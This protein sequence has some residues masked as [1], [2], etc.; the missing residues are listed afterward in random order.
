[1]IFLL[2]SALLKSKTGIEAGTS[3]S[4]TLA[5]EEEE[6]MRLL[7]ELRRVLE[8]SPVMCHRDGTLI[9]R[10]K[11][12]SCIECSER[13]PK[14]SILGRILEVQRLGE[15]V[16]RIYQLYEKICPV[17][18]KAAG[19]SPAL[20]SHGFSSSSTVGDC[21]WNSSGEE[22]GCEFGSSSSSEFSEDDDEATLSA[23]DIE[24]PG[25]KC[26]ESEKWL[27]EIPNI[28]RVLEKKELLLLQQ[29]LVAATAKDCSIMITFS[30]LRA[31]PNRVNE[32]SSSAG[33]EE[34]DLILRDLNGNEH[35]VRLGVAD[36]DPKP[37]SSIVKHFLRDREMVQDFLQ[38]CRARNN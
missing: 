15:G 14:R 34:S 8:E 16:D 38:F 33:Y 23:E 19:V 30:P 32:D 6:Y 29:Y 13:P 17:H 4:T 24:C 37:V 11:G 36:L 5:E 9:V 31:S 21:T 1:M 35:R 10:R 18:S 20:K 2:C 12:E 7:T 27:D 3:M 25:L 22:S 26:L 28:T